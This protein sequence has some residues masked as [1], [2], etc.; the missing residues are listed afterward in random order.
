MDSQKEAWNFVLYSKSVDHHHR[1]PVYNN[2][3]EHERVLGFNVSYCGTLLAATVKASVSMTRGAGGSA[4]SPTL[5]FCPVMPSNAENFALFEGVFSSFDNV[6]DEVTKD[7][8]QEFFDMRVQRLQ[9]LYSER[10]ASPYD[11][12][13][14]GNTVLHVCMSD[15][16][17]C[18]LLNATQKAC[19]MAEKYFHYTSSSYIDE[20]FFQFLQKLQ[21]LGVPLNKTNAQ[22]R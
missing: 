15:V 4:I 6:L 14:D 22:G 9:R 12:D 7:K 18:R 10:K 5:S 8:W 2:E 3:T 19:R 17:S 21:D 1:C 11:V 13:Q 16:L 20:N